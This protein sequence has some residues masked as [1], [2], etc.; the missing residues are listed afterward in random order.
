MRNA[1]VIVWAV[2]CALSLASCSVSAQVGSGSSAKPKAAAASNETATRSRLGI[3]LNGPADWNTEIPFVDVFKLS[4]A[5]ISQKEGAGW[6][7]GPKLERDENGW[8]KRLEP[9]CFAETPMLTVPAAAYPKAAGEYVCLYD[10]EGEIRLNGIEREVSRS[11]GRI[12]FVP[13]PDSGSLFLQVRSTDPANYIRNIRVLLPGHEKTYKQQPFNPV[14]LNRWKG[15]NTYRFMDWMLT[16][17]SPVKEWADRPLPA[18]AN[19]T[20]KG[21]PLEVMVDLCNR[22]G[23]NPWFCIPHQASDDY[24]R[25][26]ARQVKATLAPG[27]TVYIEYSNE[28]WNGQFEQTRYTD[29]KGVEFGFGAADKP[30]E[31]GWRYG[32]H[33]SVEIFRLWEEAFGGRT[34]LVR[35]IG[36]QSANPYIGEQKLTFRDA[37]KNTDAL[38]LAPYISMNLSPQGNPSSEQVAGWSA[39][40]VLEHLETKS[41]PES[42]QWMKEHKALADKYKLRLLG[43]EAGQHAVGVAGG[44]N[45]DALTTVL[46]AANRHER[47]GRIYEK[48][49]DAWRDVGGGDLFCIFASVGGWS[50][51]GSWGILEHNNDDT[52]KYRAVIRWMAANPAK[53]QTQRK[54]APKSQAR[55]GKR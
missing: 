3:N 15:M 40:Q 33:R 34:R 38:A 13:R 12:V 35:V 22:T 45:N 5:W 50:K 30:W 53:P 20:E 8:I 44:E 18:Y 49:L 10:G 19:Y 23:I 14:F 2:V 52:P 36:T 37:Y 27:L 1:F 39:E 43:Y 17:N 47:M 54:A 16:N 9:G 46:L 26:F 11:K 6:G 28:L 4:R 55:T 24:V 31:A 25:R 42:I 51:W 29:R 41:L 7:Q 21:V 32:A 48:Y